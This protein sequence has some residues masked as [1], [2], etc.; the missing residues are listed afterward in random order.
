MRRLP[1]LKSLQAF[2]SAA[3]WLS[4]S[5][6]ADELFVTP[7]AVSQQIKQLEAYLGVPLFHRKTR[8][9]QLTEDAK[10]VLPLVSSGFDNLADAV[11][12]LTQNEA[13]GVLTVSSVP[14]FAIKWLLQRLPMFS[15]LY[16]DIDVRL[17]A[18]LELRDFD[19]DG[20]DVGI[21]L[22]LGDYPDLTATRILNEEVSPVCSPL[23]ISGDCP[24]QTPEDLRQHR[25]IHVDWGKVNGQ[26]PD[27]K[28]WITA[29]GIDKVQVD[30]GPSFT[31]E[32]MAIEAA[33]SGAGI[34]LVSQAA[35]ADDLKSGRLVKPFDLALKTDIA[36][37]MVCPPQNL[38]K[39]KVKAF[40]DWLL[41]EINQDTE[42]GNMKLDHVTAALSPVKG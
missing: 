16:P 2:E 37:W 17:D 24:L 9:V 4:F 31:V 14:T 27:W 15:D 10:A 1:P 23:L 32:N 7:A 19:R 41:D 5:K 28:M 34:A 30:H 21:R 3:R 12:R 40:C 33:K 13:T 8:A 26:I 36:Y 42:R 25:L 38:R 6:A 35:V 39:A 18:S 22:G 11:D 29:A 20:I